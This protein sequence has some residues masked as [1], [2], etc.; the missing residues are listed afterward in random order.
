MG[1]GCDYSWSRPNMGALKAAGIDFAVRYH[2]HDTTGKNLTAG[3]ASALRANGIDVV[4]NWEF[5]PRAAL[6]GR[7]QGISDAA[8]AINQLV[9]C[10][11]PSNA[12]VY[13]S[14]DFDAQ[15]GDMRNIAAY[16]D[17]CT[18]EIGYDR[19]G[20]YGGF[21]P[22]Q[23]LSARNTCKYYWQTYAWSGGQWSAAA[24]LRQV[25]ND[26]TIGGGQVDI[27]QSMSGDYGGWAGPTAQAPAGSVSSGDWG[28]APVIDSL[29][30]QIGGIGNAFHDAAVWCDGQFL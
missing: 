19:V 14:I 30:E 5:D 29:A 22:V 23:V 28:I 16:F 10:G 15:A 1:K 17:G 8:N 7:A 21:Y 6:N 3:E 18:A 2:S 20:V 11:G 25:Q 24:Q 9:A 27:D 12:A 13:F 26:V 4:S